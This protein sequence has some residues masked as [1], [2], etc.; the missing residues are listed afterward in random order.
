MT[1]GGLKRITDYVK[2]EELFCLTYGD[3]VSNFNISDLIAFHKA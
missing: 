3:G 1:G 2:Y